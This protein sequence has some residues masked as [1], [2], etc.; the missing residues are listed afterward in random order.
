MIN[1][2]SIKYKGLCASQGKVK[3]KILNYEVDNRLQTI[4][5]GTILVVDK[6]ERDLVVNLDSNVVGV[7]AEIGNIGSHGAGILRQL[8]IPCIIRI[9]NITK[10]CENGEDAEIDGKT[11]TFTVY[12]EQKKNES[13]LSSLHSLKYNE[14]A[15]DNYALSDIKTN[16]FWIK[17][18]PDR[19]YQK[20]RYD[21][22][23]TAYTGGT[24]YLYHIDSKTRHASD[25]TLEVFGIPRIES[26]CIFQLCNPS[27]FVEKAKERT[28]LFST[29]KNELHE[30]AKTA[31]PES[32]D[33]IINIFKRATAQYRS[34]FKYMFLTQL[35]SDQFIE[36]Y[37]DFVENLTAQS[38][39][40][41]V[42]GLESMYVKNCLQTKI[43]PGVFQKWDNTQIAL[44]IWEG[45]IDYTPFPIDEDIISCISNQAV[46]Q[47]R[48]L[49]DYNSFRIL[50]P[51]IYQMSEEFFYMSKSINS[52]LNWSMQ[53]L[54][55]YLNNVLEL[56][57]DS[58]NAFYDMPL[59][60]VEDYISKII[61]GDKHEI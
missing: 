16:D 44:N 39:S 30:L 53:L 34:L 4:P 43:D 22:I 18:R 52:F 24:S 42:L 20:L 11:S 8:K 7:I 35:H 13:H 56:N 47:K 1:I 38:V 51:L 41:D 21:M 61:G 5:E 40:T 6:L 32:I 46:N 3:G 57:I 50:V 9:P 31:D 58:I 48:L 23:A 26:L 55:T 28:A 36:L 17:P 10:L 59:T 33:C 60:T 54:F 37:V 49:R 14:L 19:V 15:A 45:K 2:T 29:M 25:G 12:S 27:W